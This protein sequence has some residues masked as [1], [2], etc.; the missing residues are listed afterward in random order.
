MSARRVLAVVLFSILS[1]RVSSA[2]PGIA[3]NGVLPPGAV[4]VTAGSNLAVVVSDGPG[5]TT[6]WIAL[7]PA[8]AADGGYLDWRYLSGATTPPATGLS[9]ASLTFATP[10][11]PGTYE[12]R[13]FASNGYTRLATSTAVTVTASSA[14]LTV[15]GVALPAAASA[16]AGTIAS[17]AL[18][19]GPGNAAD[20]IGLFAVGGAD[21][22]YLAWDY[23]NGST[24]AP[25]SGLSAA[26][27]GFLLP[28]DTGSYEFR[29]F[30]NN[31]Y[32]RLS[33]SPT[34][35]VAPSGAHLAVNGIAAPDPA[36]VAAGSVAVV[37]VSG[38]PGSTTD[39]VG[40]YPAGAPEGGYVDW[41]YLSGTTV[42][43]ASSTA[44][45]TLSFTMPTAAGTYEFRFFAN[46]GYQR[47]TTS[48]AV[49]VSAPTALITVNGTAS[50][51]PVTVTAGSVAVIDVSGGPG[52]PTDWVGLYAVGATNGQYRDWRYLSGTTAPPAAGLA[53][54]TISFLTP[55]TAGTYEVRF[56]AETGYGLLATSAPITVPV[57][58]ARVT[59]NGVAPPATLALQ[60][61]AA[62]T[63]QIVSGPGNTTDWVALA[64]AGAPDGSY[65]AWTYLN[66]LTSPPAAGVSNATITFAAPGT[67]GS[68]EWR[69]FANNGY[70]RLATSSTVTVAPPPTCG[71]VLTPSTIH[72]AA[73]GQTGW[74]AVSSTGPGC[75]TWTA[76]S[77]ESWLTLGTPIVDQWAG[78]IQRV[79]ADDPIA[80]WTF[81][82]AFGGATTVQ[83]LTGHGLSAA[84]VGAA[85]VTERGGLNL[86]GTTGYA[87]VGA[88]ARLTMTNALSVEV[89][90]GTTGEQGR[91]VGAN[92][93][94]WD[95]DLVAGGYV[96]LRM[97]GQAL[98]SLTA[99][100]DGQQH[101][102]NATW[103]GTVARLYVDAVLDAE[104]A[105]AGTLPAS[106]GGLTMGAHPAEA[107]YYAGLLDDVVVF[108]YALTAAQV[109][110]RFRW[111]NGEQSA[112]SGVFSYTVAANPL[113][114]SRAAV[115]AAGGQTTVVT[116]SPAAPVITSA[117]PTTGGVGTQV[118]VAGAAF[119]FEQGT[120]MLWLGTKP[121]TVVSWDDA[122]IVASV[123]TGS[124]SGTVQVRRLDATS[125][126]IAFTVLTPT[127]TSVTVSGDGTQVT[128]TG[129][130]FGGAQ[131]AGQ[132]WLGTAAGTVTSWTNTQ[133]VATA[134]AGSSTG[135][136]QILQGG[137]WG[138]ALPFT[139][140]NLPPHVDFIWPNTGS[141]GTPVTVYGSGFGASQGTG[142][143]SIGGAAASVNSWSDS[144]V[145][146]T[147]AAGAKTGVL[148]VQQ[149]GVW[150]NA[151]TF[152]V[153]S[154]TSTQVTLTPN[155]ISL[156]VGGTRSIQSLSDQGTAVTG[157][158]WT[159]SDPAIIA[160]ST[161]DPPVLTAVAPGNATVSAGDASADVT[162][163]AAA[164]MPLG[165]VLWSDPSSA[166]G[167][168]AIYVAVPNY[169]TVADVFA[170]QNDGSVQAISRDGTVAWTSSPSPEWANTVLP[171]FQGGLVVATD[172]TIYRLDELTGQPSPS[173]MQSTN[174]DK[175]W[176]FYPSP[177]VHTDGTIFA[178][179][180]ACHDFCPNADDGEEGAWIVG[181]DPST[182]AKKFRAPL[183]N[184]VGI[185]TISDAAFCQVSPGP[186]P[187][188]YHS[189]PFAMTVA[190]DGYLYLSYQSID[191]KGS[192]KRAAAQPFPDATYDAFDRLRHDMGDQDR[193]VDFAAALADLDAL[194]AS[195]GQTQ[196]DNYLFLRSVL[197]NGDRNTAIFIENQLAVRFSRLCDRSGSEVTK[198]HLMRVGS[199]GS[200]SDVVV[201]E[202]VES[203]STIN[204]VS[205][206]YPFYRRTT[207]QT[208]PAYVR[209]G[210]AGSNIITNADHGALYS[211]NVSKQC[212][213]NPQD[214]P[215]RPWT[216]FTQTDPTCISGLEGHHLTTTG[217]EFAASDVVWDPGVPDAYEP[218]SPS[219]Q[220]ED[221]SFAG[222]MRGFSGDTLLV[223][224]AAGHIKWSLPGSRPVIATAGGGLIADGAAGTYAFDAGG[225]ATAQLASLPQLTSWLGS[226]Y[227]YGSVEHVVSA[228][229]PLAGTF[230]AVLYGNASANGTAIQQVATNRAQGS[231]E[232][233]PP[234]G[235]TLYS[236]Y[237]SIEL[238]T[239]LSPAQILSQYLQTFAG[240][241]EST[242][243]QAYVVSGTPVT[244]LCQKV[245]F[246]V[247]G[248]IGPGVF[249][250]GA[251]QLNSA[252]AT[253]SVVTL[254]GHPLAGWRYWR[255]FSVDTN[256][257]VVETGSI[258]TPGPGLKNYAGYYVF[259]GSQIWVWRDDLRFIAADVRR[260]GL[261]VQGSQFFYNLVNG[262]W[263]LDAVGLGKDYIAP[264]L[265]R[266]LP[267]SC[268]Q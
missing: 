152:T 167:L 117:T 227:N 218:V 219:L 17:V 3:V 112:T 246:K 92:N 215:S 256:D 90:L 87:I 75:A 238:L 232:Q 23:L 86:D 230:A 29:L 94:G 183:A 125:N 265:V 161:D 156:V 73:T 1:A 158:A 148:K 164:N 100:N 247:K 83:D 95:L 135:N 32:A 205:D 223:F 255:A 102:V 150:S 28:V 51:T 237:N 174:E 18:T 34:V 121:A 203:D 46:N 131:G 204:T 49:S 199:D 67:F 153:P 201:K 37:S 38:G 91:I 8:G 84:L 264:H 228:D 6:D 258:D 21:T 89:W 80:Y 257:V 182:G 88:G 235:A 93:G 60:P 211:W 98:R 31:T 236:N 149:Q 129:S 240:V 248:L 15:N 169:K 81:D 209:F 77:S 2:Q 41:R 54:A 43:P 85:T 76:A 222:T 10:V 128:I 177:L 20:W 192:V 108:D 79:L 254:R 78:Y 74:A 229:M 212:Y 147:V 220:L 16:P 170:M 175:A 242:N 145:S 165:T 191:S 57:S 47:L 133:I 200:S 241:K 252:S 52:N 214:D 194:Y 123:A 136:V 195:T 266:H 251:T 50:P 234:V 184:S 208:G 115:I 114:S 97:L 202:W 206:T 189:F 185:D 104:L 146:A 58:P 160:L 253:M 225:S 40:F 55:V 127:I 239:D 262:A 44:T 126:A 110:D 249:S 9:N 142:T 25:A 186:E 61:G 173:Y 72:A 168:S 159:S 210:G 243:T 231:D 180:Y 118:T 59:V 137:V 96:E 226:G 36:T 5:S 260:R 82:D 26:T 261:G 30:A 163:Y 221:G 143:V 107:D 12:L 176:G 172:Q 22:Q 33:T 162:V 263:D 197:N 130:G 101:M 179:E 69:L 70:Q 14:A 27:V 259:T 268:P 45:A 154:G 217:T 245:S 53:N 155:V 138:N 105:L 140:A 99:V 190:G 63:V 188:H 116:Q 42:P 250:V 141:A 7:Y 224:D 198:L 66:G 187:W 267:A 193:P 120:S 71:Y 207:T 119:G 103:N 213:E 65:L 122:Q 64:P 233:V 13:L 132:V 244:D 124:M 216:K 106:T 35:V 134:A 109:L 157:L 139:P 68:Y 181:I 4:S 111:D 196:P 144:V 48:G 166:A 151:K 39:W 19:G 62:A 113:G 56:F 171:D 11:T 178:T 24:S